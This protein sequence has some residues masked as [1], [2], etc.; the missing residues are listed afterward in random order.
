MD[1]QRTDDWFADRAGRITASRFCDVMAFTTGEG[2]WKSGPRKGQAKVATPLKARTDYIL[3]LAAERITGT[4]KNQVKA[5]AMEWGKRWE[6]VAKA[7]YENRRGVLVR[8][9]GF[10][11][12]P[13]FDFIGASG[14]FVVDPDGG[15]E[16][17]CPFDQ[18]VHLTTLEQGLPSEHI[19]QI[20]GCMWVWGR[21]WWDFISFHPG[22]PEHLQLYVQRVQRDE[23]YI[24]QLQAACLSLEAEVREIVQR[25]MES[26]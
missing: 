4:P 23:A 19:E 12:H 24:S 2:F 16:I 7:E 17:K 5:G 26:A 10:L 11:V 1:L 8:D 22:F 20:Q 21:A 9:V 13:H 25:R 6:P 3:Q 14:D 18:E 15:G